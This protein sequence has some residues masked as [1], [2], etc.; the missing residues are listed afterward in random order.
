MMKINRR[1]I[2]LVTVPLAVALTFSALA[3]APAAQQALQ[4]HRL[5][6]MV[7]AASAAADLAHHLQ[8][9]RAAATAL[10]ADKSLTADFKK[11]SDATDRSAERFADERERLTALP[12]NADGAV[13]RVGNALKQLPSL[14]AQVRSGSTTFSTLAFGYRIVIADLVGYRDG[15]AQADGVD[16]DIADRI[17]AAA[18]MSAASEHLGQQQVTV[19]R[20]LDAGGFT[21]ASKRTFEG[22]RLGYTETTEELFALGLPEWRSSL[23][24][25]LSGSKA[26]EA[27]RL[28]DAVGRAPSNVRLEETSKDWYAATTDRAQLMRSVERGID[29]SIRKTVDEERQSLLWL[30]IAEAVLVVLALIGTV[31]FAHRLG[32]VMIRRLRELR[33]AAHDVSNTHLPR[34]MRELS[35]P[36]AATRATPEE[37]AK[38]SSS[39]VETTTHDEI[40]EVGEAF[41]A[42][43][44]EAV[45][46][47]AEQAHARAEFAETLIGAAR[48]GSRLTSVM[49]SELDT[50]QRD[51]SDPERMQVLFALDH[52]AIRMERNTNNLLVMGGSGQG[53]VR[54]ENVALPTVLVA[55]A[56]Q[57]ENFK[58]VTPGSVDGTI[59]VAARVVHDLAHMLAELLD[60]ALK[61]SPPESRVGVAAWRLADR[62]VVQVVDEGVGLTEERRVE[63]N[64]DLSDPRGDVGAIQFMGVHVVARL[65]ARH[66]IA[67]EL[68][69]SSGPGTIVEV[70]LPAGVLV[71]EGA[72]GL[73]GSDME[74]LRAAGAPQGGPAGGAPE[75]PQPGN[76]R[77]PAA[78]RDAGP[79]RN[80]GPVHDAGPVRDVRR[81]RAEEPVR[82]DSPAGAPRAEDRDA[83]EERGSVFDP[84]VRGRGRGRAF[85]PPRGLNPEPGG[86]AGRDN[87]AGRDGGDGRDNGVGRD[88][89]AGRERGFGDSGDAGQRP[90]PSWAAAGEPAATPPPSAEPSGT[91]SSG[92]P[93]RRKG[94]TTHQTHQPLSNGAANGPSGRSGTAS[95]AGKAPKKRDSRQV[96]DV[97]AAYTKG[98]SRSA[99]R[100]SSAGDSANPAKA[101]PGTPGN[102]D[103]HTQRSSS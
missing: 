9:E 69:E 15:I 27:Q 51:E 12:A 45:R 10:V 74:A 48:R 16:S 35:R 1:L 49:V 76:G 11:T 56:Q 97:F 61:F 66:G 71:E 20:A 46:L 77:G 38:E 85:D 13:E 70:T 4:A 41:N 98:I 50:V 100:R 94:A 64:A 87:S 39:L 59:V 53:R 22:T 36:G 73:D 37:I 54:T 31:I 88:G 30:A 99:N 67:V 101:Q 5:T 47:A 55:A 65:A 26:A 89:G 43:H 25:T 24:R 19:L 93:L 17:R 58:R 23:E 75:R 80:A 29:D 42:V 78:A 95:G 33:N 7:E 18:A 82:H 57:V 68:R 84:P 8:R 2:L 6:V 103:P 14:R 90:A 92:L 63:L 91:T 21:D 32:R 44:Y 3:L 83:D 40:G 72:E 81:E 79:A 52:L 28:E 86:P 60:N 96:S 34:M 62:A 102:D